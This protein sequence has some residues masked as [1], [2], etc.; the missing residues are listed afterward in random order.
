M[1]SNIIFRFLV[2]STIATFFSCNIYDPLDKPTNNAQLLSKAR[3]CFDQGDYGCAREY[4][5][6]LED[7]E[8]A[9]SEEAFVILD[10]QRSGITA[11]AQAVGISK[12]DAAGSVITV[13]TE[14]VANGAGSTRRSELARAYLK[15]TQISNSELKGF[16]RF[17]AALAI[18]ASVLA[19]ETEIQQDLNFAKADLF[20]SSGN[21]TTCEAA[22]AG[23]CA[24][25]AECSK[26]GSVISNS[27][28]SGEDFATDPSQVTA[29]LA[30]SPSIFQ[31]IYAVDAMVTGLSEM[32]VSSGTSFQIVSQLSAIISG[33]G[34][35]AAGERCFRYALTT[36]GVGR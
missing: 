20:S 30:G 11:L 6:K 15:I 21:Q 12:G 29:A 7:S 17:S 19:E 36:N 3:A 8:V 23:A 24:A 31:V 18:A 16:V 26:A 2:G 14:A 10:E 32:G 33:L 5:G 4:Y 27:A 28:H 1:F 13:M 34:A 9:R 22:G 25:T 35:G